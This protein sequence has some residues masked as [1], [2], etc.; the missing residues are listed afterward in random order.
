[1]N[2]AVA[3]CACG[4]HKRAGYLPSHRNRCPVAMACRRDF[5]LIWSF[6]R[7][8]FTN[9]P[10]SKPCPKMDPEVGASYD[11]AE[12]G[13]V[14]AILPRAEVGHVSRPR[15]WWDDNSALGQRAPSTVPSAL[16]NPAPR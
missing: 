12:V 11:S 16:P 14:G 10:L 4:H 1:M 7:L 8:F 6:L 9:G 2:T 15:G 13:H 5:F 3:C